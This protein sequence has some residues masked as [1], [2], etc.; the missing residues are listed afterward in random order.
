M[1]ENPNGIAIDPTDSFLYVTDAI[2]NVN[3][4]NI[5]TGFST[6]VA[7]NSTGGKSYLS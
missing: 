3:Q 1:F 4:I 7:G 6:I 5:A 2:N